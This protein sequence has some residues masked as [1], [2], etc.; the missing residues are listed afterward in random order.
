MARGGIGDESHKPAQE[1]AFGGNA[2]LRVRGETVDH[3][4]RRKKVIEIALAFKEGV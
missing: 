4:H 2:N 3:A 1:R